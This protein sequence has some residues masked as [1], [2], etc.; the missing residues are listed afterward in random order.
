MVD[1]CATSLIFAGTLGADGVTL[2][3]VHDGG[4]LAVTDSGIVVMRIAP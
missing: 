4:E 3:S 1:K 2:E